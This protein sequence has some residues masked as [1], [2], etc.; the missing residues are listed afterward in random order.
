[1]GTTHLIDSLDK[2]ESRPLA[3][4]PTQGTS[5]QRSQHRFIV[6]IEFHEAFEDFSVTYIMVFAYRCTVSQL[7]SYFTT[8]RACIAMQ[9]NCECG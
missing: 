9:L 4:A 2:R 1:M 8:K 6:E 3:K 5:C 7:L